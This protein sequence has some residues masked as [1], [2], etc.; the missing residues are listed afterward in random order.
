V[1]NSYYIACYISR[2]MLKIDRS[3]IYC[4]RQQ[5][6]QENHYI[7]KRQVPFSIQEFSN[8]PPPDSTLRINGK[9]DLLDAG[10]NIVERNHPP[11]T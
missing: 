9:I 8:A 7:K 6:I 4:V 3:Q 11:M 10:D 1:A 5:N 2:K